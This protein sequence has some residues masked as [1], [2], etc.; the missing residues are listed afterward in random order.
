MATHVFTKAELEQMEHQNSADTSAVT[1]T[2]RRFKPA[3]QT[4]AS[5]QKLIKILCEAAEVERCL[6]KAITC[7]VAV[8]ETVS[9]TI[10]KH[11]SEE[12]IRKALE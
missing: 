8:G 11:G 6:V 9:F 4:D 10:E 12:A 3:T 5:T 2:A 7:R 1:Y